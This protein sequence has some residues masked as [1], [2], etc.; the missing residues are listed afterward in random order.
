VRP[1]GKTGSRVSIFENENKGNTAFN[2]GIDVSRREYSSIVAL[3]LMM[4]LPFLCNHA[5]IAA[6][7]MFSGRS[8]REDSQCRGMYRRMI[9]IKKAIGIPTC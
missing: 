5:A 7:W 9:L 2:S 6:S 8:K 3:W 4:D 1:E